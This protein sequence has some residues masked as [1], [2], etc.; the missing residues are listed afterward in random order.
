[1]NPMAKAG[2]LQLARND[3]GAASGGMTAARQGRPPP[4]VHLRM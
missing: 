2:G 4:R 3:K 1:M